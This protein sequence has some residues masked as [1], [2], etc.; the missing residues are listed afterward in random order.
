MSFIGAGL[1]VVPGVVH[2][3]MFMEEKYMRQFPILVFLAGGAAYMVGAF[4]FAIRWPERKFPHV[5][6]YFGN[7]HNIFHVCCVVGAVLC[8][9]GSVR[10][11]HERQLYSCPI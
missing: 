5:F 11:F 6:D 4:L 9:W 2:L 10:V 8:W 1:S 3:T 7:S